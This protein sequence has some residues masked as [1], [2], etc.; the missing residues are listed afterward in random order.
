MMCVAADGRNLREPLARQPPI[1]LKPEPKPA[2]QSPNI[3][4]F[5]KC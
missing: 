3:V 5:R 2:T 4:D 1:D